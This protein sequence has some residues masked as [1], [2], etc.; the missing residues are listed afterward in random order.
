MFFFVEYVLG[1]TRKIENYTLVDIVAIPFS[2]GK[3]AGEGKSKYEKIIMPL[4]N[5]KFKNYLFPGL[6]RVEI[7]H[8]APQDIP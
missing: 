2:I 4:L 8:P 3:N 6:A 1:G 7:Y 5:W